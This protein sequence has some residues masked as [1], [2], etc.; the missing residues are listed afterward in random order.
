M[1]DLT[2][3]TAIVAGGSGLIGKAVVKALRKQGAFT[4]NIDIKLKGTVG[5]VFI[6][7]DIDEYA[8]LVDLTS[9]MKINIFVNCAYPNDPSKHLNGFCLC[10]EKIAEHMADH[11]GGS[12]INLASIYGVVGPKYEIYKDTRMTMPPRYAAVKGG[13][14]A[15]SR[16][17]AV[18]YG[19]YGVR[20]NC[21]SP[22]GVFDNQPELFVKRY[23]A[24][25]PMGKMATP[26]D[27][28]GAVVF[29]A[30]DEASYITGQNLI[31][32]GGLTAI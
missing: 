5:D 4:Y 10:T 19:K 2:N 6:P 15:H 29:L 24:R 13:I 3:K 18:K 17:M 8:S 14:I 23:C 25:V 21:V 16:C 11:G 30:S 22:G 26:E 9:S 31:V 20:I 7:L 32:D 1:F 12:V 28:A 27:I